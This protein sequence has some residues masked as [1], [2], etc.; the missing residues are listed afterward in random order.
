MRSIL[1][2]LGLSIAI[3]AISAPAH[4]QNYPW[5]AFYSGRGFGGAT[6]CGFTS[7]QQCMATVSGIGG[8]CQVNTMYV[9]PPGPHRRSRAQPY[10]Y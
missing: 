3:S 4:A 5:C 9:P 8:S 1:C 10:P 7:F 2:V 6:N